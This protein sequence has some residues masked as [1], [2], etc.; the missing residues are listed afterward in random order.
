MVGAGGAKP[1]N[2]RRP[3]AGGRFWLSGSQTLAAGGTLNEIADSLKTA[4]IEVVEL[5]TISREPEVA[6]VD[7]AVQSILK[8]QPA[9]GDFVLGIGGGAAM[10]L[11][12]AVAALATNRQGDSVKDFLEGV[13]AGL[14]D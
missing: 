4:G 7:D 10:D 13:G 2:W 1:G 9:A 14:Q 6:D 8:H 12:K 5:V 3:W 11:A